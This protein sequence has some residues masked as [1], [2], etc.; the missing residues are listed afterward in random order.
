MTL[1]THSFQYLTTKRIL[2]HENLEDSLIVTDFTISGSVS[3]P[4]SGGLLDPDPESG[5]RGF[6]KDQMLNNHDIIILFSNFYNI[7]SFN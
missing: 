2:D 4:D 5:S 1:H 6:K 7:F 3:D